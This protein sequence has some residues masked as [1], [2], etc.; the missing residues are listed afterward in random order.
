MKKLVDA[1]MI[2]NALR[3]ARKQRGHVMREV[4]EAA[5]VTSG[6]VG[7][8]E[9]G[10][11][12]MSVENLRA[13]ARFLRID[14]N[15]LSEGEVK[16]LGDDQPGQLADAEII[17]D[18]GPPSFGPLD[19]EILGVVAGGDD[20]DFSLNGEVSGYARRPAGI[21]NLRRVFA[22]HLISTS[23]I[24]RYDPGELIYCGGREPVA[25]D[26]VVIEMHP[27]EEGGVGKA[28]VKKLI[29][30]SK[31]KLICEQYNPPSIIEFDAY[32]IKNLWRV[33][34]TRELLGF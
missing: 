7:N 6:A 31:G 14:R 25:G 33:I 1:K 11:N 28:F 13:V 10:A 5:G 3:I 15:A 4:A 30:R 8:W 2:G 16:Y 27:D 9:R 22:L 12:E 34:P 17:T 29:E 23:M 19:V 20:G 32:R 18:L 21:A 24:P 26:H